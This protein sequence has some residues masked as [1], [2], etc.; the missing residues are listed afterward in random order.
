MFKLINGLDV[1]PKYAQTASCALFWVVVT[2][3][4]VSPA[5]CAAK[6]LAMAI[7][8]PLI[9]YIGDSHSVGSFGIQEDALLRRMEGFRVA[10]YATCGSS[11]ESWLTGMKT[12]CGY[13]FKNTSGK[14]RR[15]WD[16]ETPLIVELLKTHQPRYTVVQLGANMYGGTAQWMEKTSHDLA[17]S[18]VNSGSKCI[19]IGPPQARIQSEAGVSRIYNA[20]KSSVGSYCLL[21]DSRDFTHYPATGGDGVHFNTLGEPGQK[22]AENWALNAYYAFSPVLTLEKPAKWND[23][24]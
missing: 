5:I 17:M 22:I 9:L 21:F 8:P 3:G 16:A 7:T 20:L 15:G 19:W 14:E 23:A 6:D 1:F 10:S 2:A 24:R 4:G 12:S 13:V 11:P 18:I